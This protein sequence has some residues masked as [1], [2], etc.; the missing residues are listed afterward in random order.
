MSATRFP[1]AAI[2][3]KYSQ[4]F[5]HKERGRYM[6]VYECMCVRALREKSCEK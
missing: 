6:G 1:T 3:H 2:Y 5:T 4:I